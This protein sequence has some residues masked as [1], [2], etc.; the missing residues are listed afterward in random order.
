VAC[1]AVRKEKKVAVRLGDFRELTG[2]YKIIE[3]D[4]RS[5]ML[6]MDKMKAFEKE[7]MEHIHLENDV[8]IPKAIRLDEN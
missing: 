1:G 7:L 5:Y 3:R 2:D 8:L 6:L 4:C